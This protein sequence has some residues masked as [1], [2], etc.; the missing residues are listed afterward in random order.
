MLCETAS[1]GL[2]LLVLSMPLPVGRVVNS[3]AELTA[4]TVALCVKPSGKVP[5]SYLD[6]GFR[7]LDYRYKRPLGEQATLGD[8]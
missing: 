8:I 2:N 3:P 5:Q 1:L 7:H 6:Y 4:H